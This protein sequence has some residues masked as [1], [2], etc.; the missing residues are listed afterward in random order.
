MVDAQILP[1]GLSLTSRERFF[2]NRASDSF[3]VVEP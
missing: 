1:L 2:V 3:E